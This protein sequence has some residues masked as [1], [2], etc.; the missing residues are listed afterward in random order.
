ML[1]RR[2]GKT[3]CDVSVLGFGCM[4]L[5]VRDAHKPADFFDPAKAI[6]EEKAANLIHY[7]IEQGVNYF[8]TAYVYHGGKSEPLLG[9]AVRGLRERVYLAT[10]L[11]AWLIKGKEDFEK[12]FQEQLLRLGTDFVDFYLLHGL[13]RESWQKMKEMGALD[14]LE[15]VKAEGKIR[16]AGFS[17]HDDTRTFKEIAGAYDWALCLIQHNYYDRNYQA[18]REGLEYA[19]A[20][21]I[22]VVIMEPLRGG[23]LAQRIPEEVQS[24]WDSSPSKRTPA[25]WALRWVWNHPGV[26]TVLSGMNSMEQLWEN[27]RVA[28][29]AVAHSL[30]P[31][32]LAL[33]DR[34]T[35]AYRKLLRVNCT[36]C[37]YCLPCPRG[38]NIP[39][40]FTL[41]NDLFAFQTPETSFM[42]YQR[43]TAPEQRAANC[44][45]CGECQEKCPQHI[46]IAREMK[47]VHEALGGQGGGKG[48]IIP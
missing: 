9:K 21:G 43:M 38:V 18:G 10:K 8:D 31:Q 15:R 1:Y 28:H 48:P 35:D 30:N 13:G 16:F 22:G 45:D 25:E 24:L 23:K 36:S 46:P 33:V 17:F 29:E 11:P 20:R 12:I 27:L 26:S 47:K 39:H 7:A 6:D 37:G 41:Y 2:L 5:P 42:L 44:A 14:F 32:E 40:N 4:R 19:A 3:G 34:V